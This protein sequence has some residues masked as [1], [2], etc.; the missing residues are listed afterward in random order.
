MLAGLVV[1]RGQD[2][3][4]RPVLNLFFSLSFVLVI[5]FWTSL[6][7]PNVF[8]RLAFFLPFFCDRVMALRSFQYLLATRR[9]GCE[10][11]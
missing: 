11:H 10:L 2:V 7:R 1:E 4:W 3:T 6:S 9:S 5:S 8:D